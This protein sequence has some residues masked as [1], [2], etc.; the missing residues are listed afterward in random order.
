[1]NRI[2]QLKKDGSI[3]FEKFRMMDNFLDECEYNDIEVN[4]SKDEDNF[5]IVTLIK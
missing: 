5:Y 3:T 2:E 4:V 1:M